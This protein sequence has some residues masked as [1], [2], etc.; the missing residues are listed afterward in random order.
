MYI[1]Y[2]FE[3]KE[4]EVDDTSRVIE[5][6]GDII[7]EAKNVPRIFCNKGRGLNKRFE[8]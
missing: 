7:K 2:N 1:E 4:Q 6:N 8:T 5:I 3:G